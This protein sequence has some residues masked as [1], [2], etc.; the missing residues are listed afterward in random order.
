[1]KKSFVRRPVPLL[2]LAA[3]A[4]APAS[5]VDSLGESSA[6]LETPDQSFLLPASFSHDFGASQTWSAAKHVRTLADVNGD[7][8]KD[9]VGFGDAGV[10]LALSQGNRFE[11]PARFVINDLGADHAWSVTKHVRT[12]ADINADGRADIVAFGDQGVWTALSNGTSFDAPRYVRAAFGYNQ[13]W[14]TE[15]HVRMLADVNHDNRQDIVGFG[16][17]GVYVSLATGA[18]NFGPA[19][20][21]VA[22]FGYAKGWDPKLHTRTA[23]D[24]NGDG[25]ADVVAFGYHG[26]WTALATESGSFDAPELVLAQ[27]GSNAGGWNASYHVRTLHDVDND[28]DADIIGFG[29]HG[30]YLSRATGDGGFENA[31][32]VS[33][34]FGYLDGWLVDQHPRFIDDLNDDGFVDLVGF[35]PS[36]VVRA[37][38]GPSG[39]G[40]TQSYLAFTDSNVRLVGDVSGDG[41]ADL[42]DFSSN[43]VMVAR[44]SD[45]PQP[46]PPAAPSNARVTSTSP[47]SLSIAWNDNSNNESNFTISYG[48]QSSTAGANATSFTA[49]SL[50]ASTSYTFSV[51]ARNPYGLSSATSVTG[52]TSAAPPPRPDI[53]LWGVWSDRILVVINADSSADAVE[54]WLEP[55]DGT[56]RDLVNGHERIEHDFTGLHPHTDYCVKARAR[57]NGVFSSEESVC[58]TTLGPPPCG[59][60]GVKAFTFCAKNPVLSSPPNCKYDRVERT[61]LACTHDEGKALV[62]NQFFNWTIVD[63]S[64]PPCP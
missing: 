54:S 2:L 32:Y 45:T 53:G 37:L 15:K 6:A 30:A 21:A 52:T 8:R 36:G 10:Y 59:G 19:A 38:G 13:G 35:G 49:G 20:L 9:V 34:E 33:T 64:C 3:S 55:A 42:V 60:N 44:S 48:G 39:F 56:S 50:S 47:S 57:R 17:D 51:R 26:V 31:V 18:G 4:C 58:V 5:E 46:P 62:Q 43:D 7:G 63:G 14:R 27:Y 16:E 1:M 25:R 12:L 61:V 28:G 41:M 22:D 40:G 24:V 23:A 11:Q 29:G